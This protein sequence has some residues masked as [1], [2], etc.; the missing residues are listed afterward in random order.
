[1]RRTGLRAREPSTSRSSP[2]LISTSTGA[3]SPIRA[4]LGIDAQT[5]GC[6]YRLHL[7]AYARLQERS[8]R[9]TRIAHANDLQRGARALREQ[10]RPLERSSL[11]GAPFHPIPIDSS[12]RYVRGPHPQ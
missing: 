9:V 2:R 3:A 1:M 11:S 4:W 8:L 7:L 12:L 10:G 6:A 5:P